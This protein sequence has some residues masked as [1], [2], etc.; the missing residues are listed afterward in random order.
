MLF[1]VAISLGGFL[2]LAL[3]GDVLVRGANGLGGRLSLPPFVVGLVLVALGTSAPEMAVSIGAAVQGQGDIAV[4]NVIG[5]NIVNISLV[6]GLA[7]LLVRIPITRDTQRY[8]L[9][10]LLIMSV[11]TLAFI[12]NG[13]LVRWEGALLL[14]G[15]LVLFLLARR[16]GNSAG[17]PDPVDELSSSDPSAYQAPHRLAFQ[18]VAGIAVLVAGAQATIVGA[19]GLARDIGVSEAVIALSVT[20][21]GTSLPEIAASLAAV[22]R[23]QFDIAMGNIV[24]SNLANIGLVLSLSA[25]ATPLTSHGISLPVLSMFLGLTVLLSVL[26]WWQGAIARIAGVGFLGLYGYYCT[27]LFT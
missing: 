13:Q 16:L 12:A 3:G 18:L 5:S 23:R 14:L 10:A 6:L 25:L 9:P 15:L 27:L 20:A 8:H 26:A 17:Q 2:M 19:S 22:A 24:G 7:A 21:L 11:L 4:G 1:D